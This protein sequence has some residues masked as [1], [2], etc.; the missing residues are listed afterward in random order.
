[1]KKDLDLEIGDLVVYPSYGVGE[2]EK[3]YMI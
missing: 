2:I 1:M 3:L